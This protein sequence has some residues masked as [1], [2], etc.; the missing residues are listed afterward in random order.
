M[1][2]STSTVAASPARAVAHQKSGFRIASGPAAR[3]EAA[4]KRRVIWH[5]ATAAI[6]M[7]AALLAI[8][9]GIALIF[10]AGELAKQQ[11]ASDVESLVERA[12]ELSR[13]AD[14]IRSAAE[15]EIS[16]ANSVEAEVRYIND[17]IHDTQANIDKEQDATKKQSLTDALTNEK[18][19]LADATS[20][21]QNK[22]AEIRSIVSKRDADLAPILESEKQ[23]NSQIA[24]SSAVLE[25]NSILIRVAAVLLIVF[26]VQTFI[27][28][29]RYITRLAAYY[30]ARVDALQL[31]SGI[32]VSIADLQMLASIF[33]PETYDFGKLPRGP[34]EQALDLARTIIASQRKDKED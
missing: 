12:N 6:L 7:L 33:S 23:L 18:T 25:Y 15:T 31:V 11:R 17:T 8:G 29:F 21:L 27:T 19:R 28:I 24:G 1:S 9:G 10:Y 5:R 14:E 4:L 22:D 3:L 16:N 32:D 2:A 13:R 26:L 20:K 30:Q 34:T